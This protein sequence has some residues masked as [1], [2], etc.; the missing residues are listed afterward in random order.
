MD[1][2]Q[3][4][5][6]TWNEVA[7]QYDQKF[8]QM[9]IY[10]MSYDAVLELL[11][12]NGF[13]LELGCASGMV[14][15]YFLAKLPTLKATG[16]DFAPA[17]IKLARKNLPQVKFMLCDVCQLPIEKLQQQHAILATFVLPY[18]LPADIEKFFWKVKSLLLPEGKF[19]LSFVEGQ[20]ENGT[21][22]KN[23]EGLEV[24]FY[25]YNSEN[26]IALLEHMQFKVLEVFK[27]D[28][29]QEKEHSTH[30]AILAQLE[31]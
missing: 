5:Q 9:R 12:A 10:D 2:Y 31:A 28:Y 14:L 7:I 22:I 8:S 27:F 13:V 6:G 29:L 30:T 15:K 19:Y 16:V 3:L 25:Y 20:H 1:H 23:G 24:S 4:N 18:L 21:V 11:P 26:I 17:M